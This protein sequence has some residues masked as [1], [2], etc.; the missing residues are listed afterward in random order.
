MTTASLGA[1]SSEDG[2]S[3]EHLKRPVRFPLSGTPHPDNNTR[4]TGKAVPHP[5]ANL[6]SFFQI[7]QEVL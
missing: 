2:D 3:W 5:M 4:G 1:H 6:L 7:P